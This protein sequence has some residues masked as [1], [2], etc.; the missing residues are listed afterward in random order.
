MSDEIGIDLGFAG[1]RNV[2][3]VYWLGCTLL[4]VVRLNE[5]PLILCS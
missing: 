4:L 2:Q 1:L 5:I 3:Y